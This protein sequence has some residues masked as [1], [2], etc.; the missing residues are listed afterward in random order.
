MNANYLIETENLCKYYNGDIIKA[1][2]GVS[3]GIKKGEVVVIIGPSGSGKSTYL[4]SLNLLE[5][6]TSG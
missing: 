6:P 1:L 2:D 5:V 3:A 4:R